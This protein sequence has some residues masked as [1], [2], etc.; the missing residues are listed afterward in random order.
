MMMIERLKKLFA[1]KANAE[2][3]TIDDLQA[4]LE[5]DSPPLILDVRS[6]EEFGF[7]GHIVGAMLLPVDE[8]P[9]R[10]A[11]I[12]ADRQ[13]VCVCRT[14]RRSERAAQWLLSQGYSTVM[15][16]EGGMQAWKNAGL[17]VERHALK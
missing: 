6:K 7:H 3:L 12:P 11:E 1:P 8:L 17:P 9:R 5:N 15:V 4:Q 10:T 14:D 13:V 2:W 16:L